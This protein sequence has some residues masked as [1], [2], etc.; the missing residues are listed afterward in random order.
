MLKTIK[1]MFSADPVLEESRI[2]AR[3]EPCHC[4]S[5]RKYKNCCLQKD[6]RKGLR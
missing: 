3:N 5:Q 2:P 4:G 6:Q 1:K